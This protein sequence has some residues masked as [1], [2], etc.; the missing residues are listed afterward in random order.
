[1][2]NFENNEYLKNKR[3]GVL[4]PLSSMRSDDDFGCGDMLSL[5]DWINYLST[6]QI[7]I[8]QILPIWETAPK[9]NCPYSALTAFAID[10]VYINIPSIKVFQK[11]F[12]TIFFLPY[13]TNT[14]AAGLAFMIIFFSVI[15]L[16]QKILLIIFIKWRLVKLLMRVLKK[17][18][19]PTLLK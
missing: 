17:I 4:L 18:V 14:I 3:A 6:Y 5:Q 10:P 9:V 19:L 8:L 7:K 2:L 13:V 16:S 1:M 11:A 15:R 12:Q